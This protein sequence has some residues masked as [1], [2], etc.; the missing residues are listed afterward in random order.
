MN[1]IFHSG[2][3]R[4][5]VDMASYSSHGLIMGKVK[6]DNF[7]GLKG[8]YLEFILTEMF[9]E[10]SSTFHM[11]FVQIAEFDWLPGR[12]KGLI[13]EEE[14]IVSKIIIMVDEDNTLL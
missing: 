9:I 12:I 13:L 8:G 4:S 14:K 5:L 1:F 2:Q 7:F 11:A 6:I 3:I 10:K